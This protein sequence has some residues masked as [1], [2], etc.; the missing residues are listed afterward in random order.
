MWSCWI[1]KS[2]DLNMSWWRIAQSLLDFIKPM[3]EKK[4]LKQK[5]LIIKMCFT[6]FNLTF[7][8]FTRLKCYL[9]RIR[10]W[11][12]L[13]GTSGDHL[14]QG[15]LKQFLFYYVFIEWFG[16]E[17]TLKLKPFEVFIEA[18]YSTTYQSPSSQSLKSSHPLSNSSQLYS[19]IKA[20]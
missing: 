12:R 4:I 6:N 10:D 11:L 19:H 20:L 9:D 16:L 14:I 17:G 3:E 15:H 13:D 8:Q 2:T 18:K 7:F 5:C 1:L